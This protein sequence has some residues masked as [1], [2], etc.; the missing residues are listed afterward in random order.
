MKNREEGIPYNIIGDGV[1]VDDAEDAR[2]HAK[3]LVKGE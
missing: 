3:H 2:K 1:M